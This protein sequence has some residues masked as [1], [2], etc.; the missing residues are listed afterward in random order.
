MKTKNQKLT[1]GG[2]MDKVNMQEYAGKLF[3][4]H[5]PD[6]DASIYKN[7]ELIKTVLDNVEGLCMDDYNRCID[8]MDY[9]KS[10]VR[11]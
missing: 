7:I 2:K 5:N 9:L 6:S 8:T 1:N 3:G 4:F 11:K 10:L